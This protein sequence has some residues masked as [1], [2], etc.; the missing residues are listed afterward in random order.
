M[1]KFVRYYSQSLSH[2]FVSSLLT[3]G[4]NGAVIIPPDV[5]KVK[6]QTKGLKV[7][8]DTGGWLSATNVNKTEKVN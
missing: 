8:W 2:T 5:N 7:Y 4:S 6:I 1:K 3:F